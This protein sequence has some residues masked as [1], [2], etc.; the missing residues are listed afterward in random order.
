MRWCLLNAGIVVALYASLS[1]AEEPSSADRETLAADARRLNAEGVQLYRQG[2]LADAVERM[3]AALSLRQK[4]YPEDKFPDGHRELAQ[5]L[6]NLGSLLQTQRAYDDARPYYEQ[7]LAMRR[8]LYPQARFPDGSPD[9]A[10]SLNNL[11]FL[12][13]LQGN[14]EAAQPYLDQALAMRRKLY[15]ETAYPDGHPELAMSLINIGVLLK[16]Q[17]SYE[18]ARPYHEQ[19]LAMLRKLYPESKFPDGHPDLAS[20][21]NN[22][23][24]LLEDHGEYGQARPYLEQALAMRRRLFASDKFPEGHPD[25]ATSL[26]N[27]GCLLEDQGEYDRAQPNFEQALAMLRKLYPEDRYPDGHPYVAYSLNN[28]GCLL[29]LQGAYDGARRFYN[30]ALDM[31]RKLY[32]A[33]KY[34]NGH[35]D[36]AQSLHSLGFL[37]VRGSIEDAR[38]FLEQALDMRRHLYPPEMYPDG[39]PELVQ[40]LESFALLYQIMGADQPAKARYEESLAMRRGLARQLIMAASEAEALAAVKVQLLTRDGYLSVTG[41]QPDTAAQAYRALWDAKSALSRALELRYVAALAARSKSRDQFARLQEVRRRIE[42]LRRETRLKPEEREK[43]L[44]AFNAERDRL[45]QALAK[46]LPELT[47]WEER[48]GWSPDDLV[49]ALPAGAAFID[50]A[51]YTRFGQDPQVKGVAG[52]QLV[53]SYVAFVVAPGREVRRVELGPAEPIDTAVR[54]WRR[55]VDTREADSA[56]DALRVLIWEPL[57][58]QLPPEAKTLYLAPDGDLERLAWAALPMGGGRVL[59][60]QFALA[61]VPQGEQLLR[62]LRRSTRDESGSV[63][64]VWGVAYGDSNWPPLNQGRAEAAAVTGSAAAPPLA[65]TQS[66]A[67]EKR[68]KESLPQARYAHLVTHGEFR[69]EEPAAERRREIDALRNWRE[70]VGTGTRRASAKNPLGYVGLV[71]A[72]GKTLT[73]PAIADLPLENV[74]LVTLSATD[75]GSGDYTAGEAVTRLQLAIHVAGCPNVVASLWKVNDAASAALFAKFYHEVLHNRKEPI[76]ALREA[77]LTIYRR[78]DL[79]P[80]LAGERGAQKQRDALAVSPADAPTGRRADTRLW[81]AF[82]LSGPGR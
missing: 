24:S 63:L 18:R 67:T 34:P 80:D 44:K 32:P 54:A 10:F 76:V 39:H 48:A 1:R 62:A 8:K 61:V 47:R 35:P 26:N 15:P 65:L 60:E 22:M 79:I 33:T 29:E 45:Q 73:G 41:R 49:K 4:L 59:L 25:L 56:G 13:E 78:P 31:R 16:E 74:E 46:D 17:G 36:L 12:L 42:Q 30:Q 27:F 2:N 3:K 9:L 6:N 19:A 81:A 5:S 75:T 11:G 50:L 66:D 28:L 69:A 7:A 57:A 82:V 70:G 77:Q 52:V 23:G 72:G 53:P 64:T 71:L 68:L 14:Y 58:K 20:S 51:A 21:L 38:P 37:Q 40:S 55:S 43:E